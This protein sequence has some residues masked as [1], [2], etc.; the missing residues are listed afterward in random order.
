MLDALKFY[1]VFHLFQIELEAI[2]FFLNDVNL[3]LENSCVYRRV[4]TTVL[5][6]FIPFRRFTPNKGLNLSF[7]ATHIF[8]LL[9]ESIC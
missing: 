5:E 3:G 8:F 9:F 7:K 1:V 4:P 2:L 6:N